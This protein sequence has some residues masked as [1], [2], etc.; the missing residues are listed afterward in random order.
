MI[1]GLAL[2]EENKRYKK[3]SETVNERL[4]RT[5]HSAKKRAFSVFAKVHF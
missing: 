1:S 2:G 3:A 5:Y 4:K